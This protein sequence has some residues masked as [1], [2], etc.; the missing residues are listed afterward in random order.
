MKGK[1]K[2]KK[3]RITEADHMLAERR[4][5]RLTEIAEHG[6]PV[7]FRS[8]IHKSPKAYDR[9]ALKRQIRK[10]LSD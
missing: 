9:K 6:K 2:Q 4:A 7:S 10:G 5:A 8:V 1:H 3:L